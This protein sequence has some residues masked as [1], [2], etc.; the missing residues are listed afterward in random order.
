[1]ELQRRASNKWAKPKGE[2][3]GFC[4]GNNKGQ[5]KK[6]EKKELEPRGEH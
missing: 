6:K 2:Y 4:F 5:F 3:K 1:M